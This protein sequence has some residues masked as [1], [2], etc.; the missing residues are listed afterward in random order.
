MNNLKETTL[1]DVTQ[2]LPKVVSAHVAAC[3]GHDPD[4]LVATFAPDALLND[5]QREFCGRDSIRDWADKEIF[6]D[7]VTLAVERAYELNGQIVMH[8]RVDG[9][10]DKSKL[11]N[12]LIL[13]YYFSI[14]NDQITQLIIILNKAIV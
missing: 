7:N 14:T 6:G 8:A 1:H 4:S 3:N 10:F 2:A 12:P 5:A 13:T 9:G 11:P